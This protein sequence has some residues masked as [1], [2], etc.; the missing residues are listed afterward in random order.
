MNKENKLALSETEGLIP[1][2]RFPEFENDGE[3]ERVKFKNLCRFIRGP[4]GGALKKEIFV[5]DGYAVFEQSHAI[6]NDFSSFRYFI[7]DEK[8]YELKRFSV[9]PNDIIMSCSGTMG[10]FG[11]VPQGAKK[12]VINQAL[13]KL[14]VNEGY[15]VHFIKE[16]LEL[17]TNQNKLLSQ[18]AGGAIKNVAEVAQIKEIN[19]LVPCPNEQQ[20]IASCLSSLDEV[21][22]AHS[23]KLGLLKDHKKGLMQNLFPQE[24][25][26]VPKYRFK[27]FEKDGE[28][29]EKKLGEIAEL[30]SSKRVHLAD[31]VSSGVPFFRG[32]E[33]SQLK[34][35]Q[36]PN[37]VLFIS[38]EQYKEIKDKYGVP[39][40]GDIL[41]TAVGTLGNV[42]CIKND[43]EFYFKDGNLI[44]M[45]NISIDSN[46][47]EVL[48]DVEKEKV[49]A[50]AIGS[51]QK[52]LTM[53]SLNK[54]DFQIPQNLKEQ[55]KIASCLSS[56][57]A[58]ITAQAQKIEQLKLHKKGLM[59]GLFPK[60]TENHP[61]L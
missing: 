25:E 15:D 60:V 3:W 11:I 7:T 42:Y 52:A 44:W 8:F 14:T 38:N 36:I 10:K 47:L 54:I 33:I 35:N 21:I 31:Y 27:E 16:T 24:G 41:I 61:T 51:S 34:N 43:D 9:Q 59:Q 18:S 13:L 28:W 40:K 6:Y 17:P 49:L 29:V 2:L 12:G 55:Q 53:A 58:L 20:K 4:F 39:R 1:E 50:S 48:L 56:L 5:R 46:F 37:D 23:Q 22:A 32:K 45:K 26:T 30:T 57:D 19:L